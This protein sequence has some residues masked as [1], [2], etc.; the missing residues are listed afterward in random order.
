[1]SIARASIYTEFFMRWLVP[2]R[3]SGELRLPAADGR[4]SLV[5]RTDV[6][7]CLAALAL[8]KPTGRHHDITGPEALDLHAIAALTSQTYVDLTPADHRI[9]MAQ[10]GEDAWWMYAFSSMFDSVREQRWTTVSDEVLRLTG[11]PPRS[12]VSVVARSR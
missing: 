9:E 1:V 5:S 10:E 6:G 11:R 7:Q 2:A 3:A 4:I 12:L 8:R